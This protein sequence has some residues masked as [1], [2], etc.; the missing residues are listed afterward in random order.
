MLS[1]KLWNL[2]EK[3][4]KYVFCPLLAL[5]L[6]LLY[7]D[8][9]YWL[10]NNIFALFLTIGAIKYG[11]IKSFRLAVPILWSLFIYDMYWVYSSEVMVTVAK[12]IN[13][14]LMMQF[15]YTNMVG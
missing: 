13:L 11:G 12:G 2:L 6:A 5:L 10:L 7:V 4:S 1:P 8:T 14:P 9:K 3:V 15:P